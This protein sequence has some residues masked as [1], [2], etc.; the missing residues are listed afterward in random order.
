VYNAL[1]APQEV[2]TRTVSP[3]QFSN[4]GNF[5]GHYVQLV[6]RHQFNKHMSAYVMGE[7]LWE[8]DYYAQRSVMTFVRSEVTFTF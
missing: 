4:A 6:L 7:G 8:G 1:L 2:P 3:A 5:R